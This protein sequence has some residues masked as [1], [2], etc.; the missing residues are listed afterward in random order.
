MSENPPGRA[1]LPRNRR[2]SGSR[3]AA[4][5]VSPTL[6]RR[7]LAKKLLTLRAQRG[8][9]VDAVAKEVNRRAPGVKMS[10][11]KIVRI[12]NRKIQRVREPD[13]LAILDVYGVMDPK[14]RDAY[15]KLAREA[16]QTGWWVGYRDVLGSGAFVDFENEASELL[17]IELGFIPGLLQTSGYARAVI[18]GS[19]V[20]D[21]A[22]I[23]RRVEARMMRRSILE[24]PDAPKLVALIDETAIRKIP[25]DVLEDQVRALLSPPKGVQVRI[26]P[27]SVGPHPAL[28]G[29]S[30]I[31][32]FR[33]D[34]EVVYLE[35]S[36]GAQFL[37]DPDEVAHH[38]ALFRSVQDVALP[39][40]E[41]VAFLEGKLRTV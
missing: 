19:G 27:D 1:T 25:A 4:L 17:T 14:E 21:P 33:Y 34:R 7:R 20:T 36:S 35:Q 2:K 30:T 28:S 38:E 24:R 32:R 10:A 37:E 39:R 40:A 9:T 22:E 13:V 8:M 41:T 26:I 23:E 15:V 6:R 12:E 11:A 18:T 16:S 5:A 3:S 31:M 29:G